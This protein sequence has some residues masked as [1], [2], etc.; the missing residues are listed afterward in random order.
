MEESFEVDADLLKDITH[1]RRAFFS[2]DLDSVRVLMPR[3]F[4]RSIAG[5]DDTDT[6]APVNRST[7]KIRLVGQKACVQVS[8]CL[9]SI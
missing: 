9:V 1:Y 5:D 4:D 2:A 8:L 3:V 7:A 6:A